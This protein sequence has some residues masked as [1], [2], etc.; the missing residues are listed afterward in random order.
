MKTFF[1]KKKLISC[2]LF[3]SFYFILYIYS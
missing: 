2:K 3:F 1:N